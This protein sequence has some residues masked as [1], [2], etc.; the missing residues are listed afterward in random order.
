MK[1]FVPD[2]EGDCGCGQGLYYDDRK[3][4]CRE[5]ESAKLSEIAVVLT[6]EAEI[7]ILKEMQKVTL[8]EGCESGSFLEDG[9]CSSCGL[10]CERCYDVVICDKCREPYLLSVDGGCMEPC[11]SGTEY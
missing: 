11:G 6:K 8:F 7:D 10:D 2:E 1:P 5:L 3:D 4:V 9:K